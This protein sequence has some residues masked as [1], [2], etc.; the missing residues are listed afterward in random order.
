MSEEPRA[1]GHDLSA[2]EGELRRLTIMFCDVVG[3]TELSGRYEPEAYRELMRTYR[4]ACCEVLEDRFEGHI[5]QLRGDGTLATFGFPVAHENDAERAVRAGL[6]LIRTLRE[7]SASD[8]TEPLEVRIG[9]HRGPVYLDTEEHDIY[10]LT[11]NVGAR[12]HGVAEPGSVVVSEEVRELVEDWFE[13]EPGEPQMVKGVTEPLQPFIV[14]GERPVPAKRSWSTPLVERDAELD[15]LRQAWAEVDGGRAGRATGVLVHGDAGVGKS[16]LVSAFAEELRA[17]D[18][19][20]VELHGSP[21]HLDAGFHPVRTLVEARN[22]IGDDAGEA[23]RLATLASDVADLGLDSSELVPLLA[24]ILG[25]S[26]SAGYDPAAT[27]GRKL[28]QQVTQAVLDYTLACTDGRPGLL[29]TENL[30]WFDGATRELLEDL[31][32]GGPGRVLVVGTSRNSERGPWDEIELRPLTLSARLALIDALETGMDEEDRVALATRSGGIPLYLEELVRAGGVPDPAPGSGVA[33]VPGSVPEV[34]YEP[35]V[36][37]LYATPSA[38]PVAATAAAVGQ[39]VDRS[40][41]AETMSISDEELDSALRVLVE[42]GVLEP[43]DGHASRYRFRHELLREV[44]YELQPPSWRRK[45]HN[46]LCDLIAREEPRDWHV[47][48]SHYERAHRYSEAAAA[49]EQAA[50]WARRRGAV[51]EARVHLTRAIDLVMNLTDDASRDHREVGLRL[52]RGFLAMSTEGAASEDASSDFDRCLEL[53]AADPQSDDMFSTLISLWP[54]YLARGELDSAR[55][56]TITLRDSL[57]GGRRGRFRAHNRG[58]FGMLDWFSGHFTRAAEALGEAADYR[59]NVAGAEDVAALWFVPNDPTVAVLVHLALAQF[60]VGEAAGAAES[61]A[62]A[63]A[64]AAPLDFPQGPW[65]AAYVM[66][67]GSWMWAEEGRL[68]LAETTLAELRDLSARHGFDNWEVIAATQTAALDGITAL[69][70]GRADAAAL[71]DYAETLSGYLEVWEMLGLRVFVPFYLTT[72]GALLAAAGD[73]AGA[74]ERYEQSLELAS[75]TSMCFYDA[76]TRRRLAHLEPERDAVVAN[77]RDALERARSQAARPFELR[78]TLD[79]HELLGEP[80]SGDLQQ[81]VDAFAD[82]ATTTELDEARARL[83]TAR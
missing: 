57:R 17:S 32:R 51:Q 65:S 3:S 26:P 42:D 73:A 35:L 43:L 72:T 60:M 25:I 62:R 54:H 69:R 30:H 76:E 41:L 19:G 71:A 68:D 56:V 46:R 21:F 82:G 44:A 14:V 61:L 28:E 29:L 31:L 5:V 11:A 80:A 20:V 50:E 53:A 40:L 33:P 23:E 66:W 2:P 58:G 70:S 37:R 47:L 45:V 49:Y 34:L 4:D 63:R 64:A 6:A 79:L 18:A 81:A 27:E 16:R 52:R 15:R 24:P 77:L 8:T 83:M 39:A 22:D 48:A 1:D 12:L 13:I 9:V 75:R 59:A 7:R 38:L 78:I 10:G 36:A 67:L 55:V 74:R